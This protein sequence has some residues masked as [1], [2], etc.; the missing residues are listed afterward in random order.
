MSENK[1]MAI[2]V[3]DGYEIDEVKSTFQK[4]VFKKIPLPMTW[5]KLKSINGHYVN[6]G[7]VDRCQN[8]E[9]REL[10][11]DV[12]PSYEEANAM[13]AMAKLCQLRDVWNGDWRP[14]FKDYSS[15]YVINV[16]SD[17]LDTTIFQNSSAPMAFKTAE[18]RD[19]FLK[20]FK[21][22]LTI[23]KPFL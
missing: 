1:E 4:I 11:S 8:G 7:R 20:T 18:L 22:L 16:C 5:E 19:N 17:N 10:N 13:L 2:V 9:P 21:D 3:P 12:F 14:D 23:A 15:K 6:N